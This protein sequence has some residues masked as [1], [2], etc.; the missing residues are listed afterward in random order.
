MLFLYISTILLLNI[1]CIIHDDIYTIQKNILSNIPNLKLSLTINGT[2][3]FMYKFEKI[4]LYFKY[5]NI[6]RNYLNNIILIYNPKVKILFNLS[7]YEYCNGIFDLYYKKNSLITDK[8]II[9]DIKF[10]NIKYFQKKSDFSFDVLFNIEDLNN[11]ITIHFDNLNELDIFKYLIYEEKS[12]LYD[13]KTFVEYVKLLTLNNLIDEQKK[14]LAY[15]PQCDSLNYFNSLINYAISYF[16]F[17]IVYDCKEFTSHNFFINAAI[18]KFSYDEI[19]KNDTHVTLKSIN[20][21]MKNQYDDEDEDL[22][23]NFQIDYIA[24]DNNYTIN[25]GKTKRDDICI[26]NAF[27]I[28]INKAK[29]QFDFLNN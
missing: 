22:I 27:K 26:L 3:G 15:Y 1:I 11:S 23:E 16:N 29:A 7:I 28:V 20:C 17:F 6:L 13:N 12:N 19:I 2:N 4:N 24:I 9:I 10:K 5:E 21:L 25:Y 18:R 14:K 8:I